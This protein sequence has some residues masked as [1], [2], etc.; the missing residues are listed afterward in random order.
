MDWSPGVAVDEEPV[1]DDVAKIRRDERGGD[2]SDVV[3]GLQVASQGEVEEERGGAVVE[4][5]EEGDRS[6]E[7]LRGRW[8]GAV[9]KRGATLMSVKSE[10]R[11]R[12]RG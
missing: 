1:A 11:A 7:D 10:R 9:M 5:A 2:P 6:G 12:R 3:E 4:S 8:A